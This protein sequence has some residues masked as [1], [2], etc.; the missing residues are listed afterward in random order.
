MARIRR[1]EAASTAAAP[2]PDGAPPPR[3]G[4]RLLGRGC[5]ALVA[6]RL[7]AVDPLERVD[8]C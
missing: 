1:A 4:S 7:A 5:D 3:R 6:E 8:A 2:P